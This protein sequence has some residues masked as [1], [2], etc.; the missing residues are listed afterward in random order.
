[1]GGEHR[2]AILLESQNIN[3]I[4]SHLILPRVG[5][6]TILFVPTSHVCPVQDEYQLL[7]SGSVADHVVVLY[8]PKIK[9]TAFDLIFYTPEWY[10]SI[11]WGRCLSCD[12]FF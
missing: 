9:Y 5:T 11:L 12:T 2:V 10:Y 8:D 6:R 1:M 7:V 4:W 3:E